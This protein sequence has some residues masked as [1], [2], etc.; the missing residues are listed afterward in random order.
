ML[1]NL[2]YVSNISVCIYFQTD[3]AD[4]DKVVQAF[5]Q[6]SSVYRDDQEVK[7]AVEET[8]GKEHFP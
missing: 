8:V 4:T 7:T 5:L 6:I 1:G 2:L 3:V